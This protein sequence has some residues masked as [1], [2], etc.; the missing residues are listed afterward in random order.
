MKYV[1]KLIR[2][3][4]GLCQRNT[5]LGS[6]CTKYKYISFDI[7]DTL[8]KR[9]CKN[10][11]EVFTLIEQEY[12]RMADVEIHDFKRQRLHAEKQARSKTANE[13]VTLDEIY[14]KLIK[15]YGI[16]VS[17]RLKQLEIKV[18]LEQSVAISS[19]VIVYNRCVD[20]TTK[21]VFITSDMYLPKEVIVEIF[22]CNGVKQPHRLYISCDRHKTKRSGGLFRLLLAENH[23]DKHFLLHIGD[24]PVSDYLKAKLNGI[25]SYLIT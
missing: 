9:K 4:V 1:N 24:N 25:H 20:D 16:N 15:Y 22:K 17:N 6:I 19:N 21:K 5:T 3:L 2:I 14:Q 7:F 11:T 10:P 23:I 8:I 12:N 13:E 18:E